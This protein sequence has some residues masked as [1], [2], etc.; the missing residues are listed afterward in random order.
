MTH[1]RT[2]ARVRVRVLG[3]KATGEAARRGAESRTPAI[4]SLRRAV[5]RRTSP[6]VPYPLIS[7]WFHDETTRAEQGA[8]PCHAFGSSQMPSPMTPVRNIDDDSLIFLG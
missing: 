7:R 3:G 2:T 6:H 8:A 5:W 1:C 4:L